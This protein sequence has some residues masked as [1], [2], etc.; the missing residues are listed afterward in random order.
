MIQNTNVAMYKH[1]LNVKIELPL[2]LLR[3]VRTHLYIYL[4][5]NKYKTR[6]KSKCTYV[7]VR[8]CACTRAASMQLHPADAR[9]ALA[10][11]HVGMHLI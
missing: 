3:H 4:T 8:P 5:T 6:A 10:I 9:I 11:G 1:I 2:Q 7:R